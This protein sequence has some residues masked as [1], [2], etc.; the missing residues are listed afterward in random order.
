MFIFGL[1]YGYLIG[2]CALDASELY[3]K[4]IYCIAT[5]TCFSFCQIL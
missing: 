2:L 1:C 3:H 4:I 5:N